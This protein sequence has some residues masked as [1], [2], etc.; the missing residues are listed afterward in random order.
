MSYLPLDATLKHF[1]WRK[2]HFTED[3]K[4]PL[5]HYRI[6]DHYLNPHGSYIRPVKAFRGSSKS[7]NTCYIALHRI[8]E[9]SAHYTLIVSD[10]ASQAES[11]IAD[12]LSMIEG[13]NPPLPYTV[14]RAVQGEITLALGSKLKSQHFL[15]QRHE[16]QAATF[17]WL[18]HHTISASSGDR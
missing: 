14:I 1:L 3:N 4:T 8:E 13:A 5:F 17:N 16:I 12:I 15:V 10:T 18:R 6:V 11:L 2:R 9:P 7:T